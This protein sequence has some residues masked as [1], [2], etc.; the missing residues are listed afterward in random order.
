MS[1][2]PK[3]QIEER[4]LDGL[5]SPNALKTFSVDEKIRLAREIRDELVDVVST[6]G[7]HLAP[8][9]GVVELT[10]A[11][12]SVF[13]T[14]KDKLIWD[15]G[16]Q[17][18][19]HK[20]LTGRLEAFRTLRQDGGCLG[21]LSRDES[22]YDVFG[23][24][25]AGTAISAALGVA[26][27]RD[28]RGGEEHVVAI[29]GDG[30][31][32]C[33]ISLEGLNNVEECTRRLIIVLNDN[34]MSIAPNVGAM[35]RYLHKLIS[36]RSYNWFKA[37]A[38]KL[39]R[40]IPLIGDEI[41]CKISK[42]EEAA[43]S[44]FVPG[45]FF[46][47]LGLR[48]LG[49]VNGHDIRAMMD[50]FDV[51]RE[52]EGP[53]LVH[54]MTEKGRGYHFAEDA[55]EKYHGL[56]P[57]NPATGE[58][59]LTTSSRTFSAVFGDEIVKLAE[60]RGDIVAITA[61][62]RSGTGLTRFA[63]R[64]PDRFFDVG[65]AEEH[66]VVFAAG[67]SIDGI[68]PVVAIYATFLQRALDCVF[69]DVCLQNLP[70]VICA[71]R[72]GIVDDGPTHHGILD[73]AFLLELPNLSILAPRDEREFSW[74]L[75]AACDNRAPV[76]IRYPKAVAD[77]I[78]GAYERRCEWGT[79]EILKEGDDLT[80]WAVGR[81]CSTALDVAKI[82]EN[83]GISTGVVDARFLKPFDVDALVGQAEKRFIATIE[84]GHV[85]GGLGGLAAFHLSNVRHNGVIGFG[86]SDDMPP[87]GTVEGI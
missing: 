34:K 25:H 60:R 73:T 46:E 11:L 4:L 2:K 12:H 10:I 45:V 75:A 20:M 7:G 29:V 36:A 79:S 74:M 32:N 28:K 18:Y 30:S 22:E 61:G 5:K 70:V 47:E 3:K 19:V 42:L 44:V 58:S 54:V 8:N 66:A 31:L 63:E 40:S 86:W 23:A 53:V 56:S 85:R 39:V 37:F 84:D 33:G 14:P 15:V 64:F 43:K 71:D 78:A 81:E 49:P 38:K 21:F 16:H 6:N 1:R 41:T 67:L 62:M 9:M 80:I 57:F 65:I 27:A 69:H 82:L 35:A 87:H 26:V 13:D 50:T 17:G 77:D 48:Y 24:G 72:S 83:R 52:F 76:V 55:P 59:T 51:V 68:V